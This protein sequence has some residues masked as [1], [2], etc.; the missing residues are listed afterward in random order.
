[1]YEQAGTQLPDAL[2]NDSGITLG[3]E[4]HQFRLR[5][6]NNIIF[7]LPF[8]VSQISIECVANGSNPVTVDNEKKPKPILYCMYFVLLL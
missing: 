3:A 1:M 5:E 8:L 4:L 7:Q 6:A 2:L